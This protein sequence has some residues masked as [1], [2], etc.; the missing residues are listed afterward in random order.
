MPLKN[1]VFPATYMKDKKGQG[2][3]SCFGTQK[4]DLNPKQK[5]LWFKV[6]SLNVPVDQNYKILQKSEN[7]LEK[8]AD[9]FIL[10]DKILF[11]FP[12]KL[13]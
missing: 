7:N 8:A 9:A 6:Y 2:V 11:V 4:E 3:Q 13:S 5:L 10:G 12:F 1:Q